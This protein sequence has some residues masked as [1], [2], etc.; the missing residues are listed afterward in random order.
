M[1]SSQEGRQPG[2]PVWSPVIV[3]GR[4][5]GS[6][7]RRIGRMVAEHLG[8][9]FYD[10]ELLAT[11]AEKLGFSRHIFDLHDEKA[12]NPLRSLLQGAFGL[13]DNFHDV[14]ICSERMYSEQSKVI[15]NISR[16]KGC[17]IVGRTA[18]YIL[19][20]HPQLISIF[21]HAPIEHRAQ[22]ILS[23]GEA[24]DLQSAIEIAKKVDKERENYYNFYTG[25]SK[26]G[27]A[28]N[29]SLS[30]DS[31]KGTDENLAE[32]IINFSRIMHKGRNEVC[33]P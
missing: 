31:S 28:E 15:R 2:N 25:D 29:Y 23:R 11:A 13:A 19:R 32:L 1:E 3:I 4:Q 9:D 10:S 21:I 27:K 26:W 30:L 24:E 12:P 22:N 33:R 7:G 14:S 8:L 20:D 16:G 5:F 6:R 18:D 17:V